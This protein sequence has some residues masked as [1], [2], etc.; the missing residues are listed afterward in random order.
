MK[1]LK[2]LDEIDSYILFTE[3]EDVILF[4]KDLNKEIWRTSMPGNAHCGLLGLVNEWAVI[5]GEQLIIWI[6]NKLNRI[7]D[8]DLKWIHDMRQVGDDEI[9]ILTDPWLNNSAIWN[10]NVRTLKKSKIKDFNNYKEKPYQDKVE[11]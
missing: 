4:D 6:D 3:C 9:K 8:S 10:F 5:G 7:A 11:W 1:D 2:S